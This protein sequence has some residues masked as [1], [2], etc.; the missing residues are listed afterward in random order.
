M[1][2]DVVDSGRAWPRRI[3][4][5]RSPGA[6]RIVLLQGEIV[7]SR[8]SFDSQTGHQDRQQDDYPDLT[9]HFATAD[10]LFVSHEL[11]YCYEHEAQRLEQHFTLRPQVGS[12]QIRRTDMPLPRTNRSPVST[13]RRSHRSRMKSDLFQCERT[14]MSSDWM[15][16]QANL[17]S[18]FKSKCKFDTVFED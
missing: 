6:V 12:I 15:R 16:L 13:M 1:H 5:T 8:L 7:D 14:L 4:Q 11:F 18:G 3:E 9:L 10:C 2:V 17:L